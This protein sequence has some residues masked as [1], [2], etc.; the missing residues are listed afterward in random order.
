M[1]FL[2]E[3]KQ[4]IKSNSFTIEFKMEND[5]VIGSNALDKMIGT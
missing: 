4:K 5:L 1:A 2:I 3:R